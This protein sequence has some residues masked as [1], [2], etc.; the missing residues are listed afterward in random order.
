MGSTS[1]GD[2]IIHSN[3]LHQET[4]RGI[5]EHTDD[6]IEELLTYSRRPGKREAERDTAVIFDSQL[7]QD[8]ACYDWDVCFFI[9]GPTEDQK[10]ECLKQYIHTMWNFVSFTGSSKDKGL[11]GK[12]REETSRCWSSLHENHG[13]V[14]S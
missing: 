6:K 13:D 10:K 1:L 7:L 8:S 14:F 3:Q 9:V 4:G 12:A 2:A 11:K 5:T